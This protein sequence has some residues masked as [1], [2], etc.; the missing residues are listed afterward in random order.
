MADIINKK[1]SDLPSI[2]ML[3]NGINYLAV[4]MANGAAKKNIRVPQSQIRSNLLGW[5][6]SD[7]TSDEDKNIHNS[8]VSYTNWLSAQLSSAAKEYADTQSS[9]V[10][11]VVNNV[12]LELPSISADAC[13]SAMS[14]AHL[15]I[16]ET[17]SYTIRYINGI[18]NELCGTIDVR[19]GA[20]ETRI[21]TNQNNIG[22]LQTEVT[23]FKTAVAN[24]YTKTE[25]LTADLTTHWQA[26]DNLTTE[27]AVLSAKVAAT[28]AD[29]ATSDHAGRVRLGYTSN[30]GNGDYAVKAT[31]DGDIYVHIAGG[32][33]GGTNIPEEEWI[34]VSSYVIAKLQPLLGIG[35]EKYVELSNLLYSFDF[36][37]LK[38]KFNTYSD[39]NVCKD[40]YDVVHIDKSFNYNGISCYYVATAKAA[41]E[42]YGAGAKELVSADIVNAKDVD[43]DAGTYISLD[44][45]T[46]KQIADLD[47]YTV[48]QQH[49]EENV[50]SYTPSDIYFVKEASEIANLNAVAELS[51]KSIDIYGV[52]TPTYTDLAGETHDLTSLNNY[53]IIKVFK[54]KGEGLYALEKQYFVKINGNEVH[55]YN[56]DNSIT[57][58][59]LSVNTANKTYFSKIDMT[60][61]NVSELAE[62]DLIQT[63]DRSVDEIVYVPSNTYVIDSSR[64]AID[65]TAYIKQASMV[66]P[67]D[68][69]FETAITYVSSNYSILNRIIELRQDLLY[70]QDEVDGCATLS[71]VVLTADVSLASE[72]ETTID[73]DVTQES[74][75][76]DVWTAIS[77]PKIQTSNSDI[78]ARAVQMFNGIAHITVKN[79]GS[80][81]VENASLS[82]SVVYAD[83]EV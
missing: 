54:D 40:Q 25:D 63:Y 6:D 13:T 48:L 33:G 49:S 44:D 72:A 82:A 39:F 79:V 78:Q 41:P 3:N 75:D 52:E 5:N 45:D 10:L 43:I 53:D 51:A 42:E 66:M 68:G 26:F 1:I 2:Q 58:E 56:I 24:D 70:A 16:F 38:D 7:Y 11:A 65:K 71:V 4:T 62:Y 35:C 30:P 21:T 23:D 29:V 83:I 59:A 55:I 14:K 74:E 50:Y 27:Y 80:E 22:N 67:Y 46:T 18:S 36:A 60:D 31:E 77:V 37:S 76:D 19:D 73:I 8:V 47:E 32:G 61:H 9:E 28:S 12:K 15:S 64:S 57:V 34:A 81:A 17:S 69:S 20:V